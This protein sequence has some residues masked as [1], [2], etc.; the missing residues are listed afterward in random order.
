MATRKLFV[1]PTLSCTDK[2]EDWIH[3]TE[4]WQCLTD[5]EKDSQG[6]A[7]YLPLNEKIR[8]RCSDIKVKDGEDGVDISIKKL[9]SLFSKDTWLMINLSR[10]KGQYI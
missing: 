1:P 4:V 9:K 10:S 8:K 5:L 3:K 7:I 2:F 6:P